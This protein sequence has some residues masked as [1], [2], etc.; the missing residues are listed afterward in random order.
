VARDPQPFDALVLLGCRVAA[1]ALPPP[2]ERRVART[3]AAFAD[4]LAPRVVVSG[5]RTWEEHVEA[6]RLA[7]ALFSRGVPREVV[8]L[9]RSSRTTREN[10]ALTARLLAPLGIVRVGIVSCDWHLPRA[11][12]S[13]RHEGLLA[14]GVPAL[15]PKPPALRRALRFLREQGAWLSD[16]A[17]VVV[18]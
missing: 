5:G 3:V 13:F 8:L 18:G 11:L 15:A 6:D 9:E 4:G 16:R 14:E 17:R 1:A 7:E 12:W 10:A 2:A